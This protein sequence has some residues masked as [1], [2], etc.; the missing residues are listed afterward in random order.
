MLVS[1]AL[2]SG[3]ITL[4]DIATLVRLHPGAWICECKSLLSIDEQGTDLGIYDAAQH[5]AHQEIL[6]VSSDSAAVLCAL[7]S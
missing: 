6:K 1:E 5:E 3:L 4:G 2:A 7:Q